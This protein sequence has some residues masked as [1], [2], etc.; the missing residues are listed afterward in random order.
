M[1]LIAS[2]LT[3]DATKQQSILDTVNLY[4]RSEKLLIL[5]REEIE[6]N[7]LQQDIQKQ[8][9]E[10]ISKQQRE[11]FL[12]EQL[13]VIKKELGLEKDDKT[14]EIEALE[15][16]IELLKLSEEATKVVE[17]EMNKLR[18]LETGSA[19]YQVSRTY[20]NW[21]TD[22]PWGIFLK[23]TSI[24]RRHEKFSIRSITD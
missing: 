4:E 23:I 12:R 1:D 24:W 19:E 6:L 3:S 13:K 10:K 15:R 8:I 21:L 7:Q 9:E 18:T 22:L 17:E 5:L 11:F 2:F 14:S 20:L 16:K